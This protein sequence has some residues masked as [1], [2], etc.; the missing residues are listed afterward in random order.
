V[1]SKPVIIADVPTLTLPLSG[2]K[3]PTAFWRTL[4]LSFKLGA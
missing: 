4:N 3:P 2:Q 1:S